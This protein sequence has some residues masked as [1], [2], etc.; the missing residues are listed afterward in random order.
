VGRGEGKD[1]EKGERKK[2]TVFSKES[3]DAKITYTR[4]KWKI[5]DQGKEGKRKD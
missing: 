5:L 1:S 3:S 4:K 2:K